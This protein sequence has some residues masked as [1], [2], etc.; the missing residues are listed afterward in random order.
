MMRWYQPLKN[1]FFLVLFSKHFCLSIPTFNWAFLE[2]VC[3]RMAD[4]KR[5]FGGAFSWQIV[6]IV[7]FSPSL[8]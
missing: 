5:V 3:N 8:K 2:I 7:G 6:L 1:G 4:L